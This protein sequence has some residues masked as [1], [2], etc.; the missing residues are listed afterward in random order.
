[1]LKGS[2]P[3]GPGIPQGPPGLVPQRIAIEIPM[4]SVSDAGRRG[5][6]QGQQTSLSRAKRKHFRVCGP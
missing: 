1:M 6:A 3:R 2:H 5:S 4:L